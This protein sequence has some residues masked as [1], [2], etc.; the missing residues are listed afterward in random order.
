MDTTKHKTGPSLGDRISNV[1]VFFWNTMKFKWIFPLMLI[2][3]FTG[4][5]WGWFDVAMTPA[6]GTTLPMPVIR[7]GPEKNA[8]GNAR[9]DNHKSTSDTYEAL[10]AECLAKYRAGVYTKDEW[11]KCK[12]D[13]LDQYNFEMRVANGEDSANSPDETKMSPVSPPQPANQPVEVPAKRIQLDATQDAIPTGIIGI[14]GHTLIIQT[15]PDSRAC[16]GSE[17]WCGGPDGVNIPVPNQDQYLLYPLH[18]GTAK[19]L[20]LIG[21]WGTQGRQF[22]I[23]SNY[24]GLIPADAQGEE[25]WLDHNIEQGY[26]NHRAFASGGHLISVLKIQ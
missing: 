22:V 23:G 5:H 1:G 6:L 16:M 11:K 20:A 2:F 24:K 4:I 10:D 25:L 26:T 12:K 21:K 13:A 7:V 17:R 14:S 19:E 8:I 15:A 3:W 9:R 18:N